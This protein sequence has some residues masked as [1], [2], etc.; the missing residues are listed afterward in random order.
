MTQWPRKQTLQ[1]PAVGVGTAGFDC[2]GTTLYLVP[3]TVNIG[4]PTFGTLEADVTGTHALYTLSSPALDILSSSDDKITS[5][6]EAVGFR[7]VSV[8]YRHFR[9]LCGVSPGVFRGSRSKASAAK[10]RIDSDSYRTNV[11]GR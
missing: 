5:I 3:G 11:S 6:A 2:H 7:S 1:Q 4:N 10:A 8:L 9:A